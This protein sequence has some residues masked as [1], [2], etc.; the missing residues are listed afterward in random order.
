MQSMNTQETQVFESDWDFILSLLPGGW[1]KTFREMQILKFGR[2]F[3]GPH[4]EENFL[5][6]MF[7]H[8]GCG[9]SFR[10]TVSRAREAKI[11][12]ITDVTLFHH[13]EKCAP[14]F[15]WCNEQI[16]HD[17]RQLSRD[18]FKDGRHWKIADGT[19][20]KE[21][22]ETGSLHRLH[23]SADLATLS[24][25]QVM[26]TSFKE[27]E[28]F[29]RFEV[30]PGDV[31]E[32][33]RGFAKAPGL[34]HIIEHGGDT[35]CRF[36]PAYLKLF[37]PD[38]TRFEIKKSLTK[39]YPGDIFD[40]DVYFVYGN[41]KYRGR[42]CAVKRS[43]QASRREEEHV[44]RQAHLKGRKASEKSL[45]L[46][47]YLLIFTTLRRDDFSDKNIIRAYRL[48]WQIEMVFK[49]LKS[50]LELGQLHKYKNESIKAFLSG[51]ILISLLLEKMINQAEAF[52]PF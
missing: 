10:T 19:I 18:L 14:F 50:L 2:K 3:G 37:N 22:G 41:K 7:M 45:F 24:T 40:H 47:R 44:E 5:R 46:C 39:L 20:V 38:G 34:A 17:N 29:A 52:S 43:E 4:S 51:K 8:L 9:Y 11:V 15:E 36:T 42:V 6:V 21:Q 25:D 33:D 49:R 27:G 28:S 32:G 31:W 12:D 48:R 1:K 16:I 30:R 26:I 13:F 23:Y 35:L